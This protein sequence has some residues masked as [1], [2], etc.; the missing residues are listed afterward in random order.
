MAQQEHLQPLL[1]SIASMSMTPWNQW[2]IQNPSV[3]PDLLGVELADVN[4]TLAYLSYADLRHSDLNRTN[5]HRATLR[6]ADLS[7]AS[8]QK[9]DLS[10]ADLSFA[11]LQGADL[12]G[13]VLRDA[14]L[15]GANLRGACLKDADFRG[16]DLTDA[17]TDPNAIEGRK[18][19]FRGGV[20]YLEKLALR[21]FPRAKEKDQRMTEGDTEPDRKDK[22]V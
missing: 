17:L 15:R 21:L 2:R 19:G 22:R 9:A 13:A 4:L 5:L 16:A 18:E 20:G 6:Y 3:R 10:K 8:L 7:S 1:A 14:K 11:V 12:S